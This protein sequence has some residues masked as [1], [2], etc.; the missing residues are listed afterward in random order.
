VLLAPKDAMASNKLLSRL[1]R[2]DL[3]LLEPHLQAVELPLR[4][5][6]EARNKGRPR[7]LP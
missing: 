5:Q 6:L 1:S 4:T 7:L 3:R 2:A